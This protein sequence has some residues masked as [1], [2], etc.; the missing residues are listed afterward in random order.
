[1]R[2]CIQLSAR[3]APS[4]WKRMGARPVYGRRRPAYYVAIA[5]RRATTSASGRHNYKSGAFHCAIRAPSLL[6]FLARLQHSSFIMI[7]HST[8]RM[9][10]DEEGLGSMPPTRAQRRRHVS[11]ATIRTRLNQRRR[12]T[13]KERQRRRRRGR[14][15]T[16]SAQNQTDC[17]G[18]FAQNL[19]TSPQMRWADW[20]PSKRLSVGPRGK[21]DGA[22]S[23]IGRRRICRSP[24]TAQTPPTPVVTATGARHEAAPTSVNNCIAIVQ[25][26]AIAPP[27]IAHH[28]AKTSVSQ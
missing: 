20:S 12:A 15:A 23:P 5:A 7:E 8:R 6:P 10:R 22:C 4:Q 11:I 27:S 21:E 3:R 2:F 1:L 13:E 17:A 18:E 14:F 19:R 25:M 9:R 24:V 26:T 28:R 16:S